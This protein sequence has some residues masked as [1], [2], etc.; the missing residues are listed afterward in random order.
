MGYIMGKAEGMGENWHGHVTALTVAPE[1][2]RIGLAQ[3]FCCSCAPLHVCFRFFCACMHVARPDENVQHLMNELEDISE[4]K[5]NGYFVDLFVRRSNILAINMYNKF[6]YSGQTL[7]HA[8]YPRSTAMLRLQAREWLLT[9]LSI[10]LRVLCRLVYRRVIGYYS[11]EEDAYDMRKALPRD[12]DKKSIIP[13]DH[14]GFVV[15]MKESVH[16][17]VCVLGGGGGCRCAWE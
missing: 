1:F 13:L 7:V 4:K 6:G 16:A 12:V 11:G 17:R 3:V 14:P 9:T 2:R 8:E 5:H 15:C 10:L